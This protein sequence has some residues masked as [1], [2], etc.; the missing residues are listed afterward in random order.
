MLVYK[1][2]EEIKQNVSQIDNMENRLRS[3]N[4]VIEGLPESTGEPLARQVG[5][6]IRLEIVDFKDTKIKNI[7]RVGKPSGKKKKK[8]RIVIVSLENPADKEN[9]L[10]KAPDKRKKSGNQNLWLKVTQY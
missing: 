5:D 2:R 6:I 7:Y 9:I 1:N 3:T 10:S 4:L 8:P